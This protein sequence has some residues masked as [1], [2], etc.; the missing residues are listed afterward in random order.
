MPKCSIGT[1]FLYNNL[2]I[3]WAIEFFTVTNTNFTPVTIIT[4]K[5]FSGDVVDNEKSGYYERLL[6]PVNTR[7]PLP[8][9]SSMAIIVVESSI[10][11]TAIEG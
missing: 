2:V 10:F 9:L 3:S 6:T 5:R 8:G 1:P 11:Y 7:R 4:R